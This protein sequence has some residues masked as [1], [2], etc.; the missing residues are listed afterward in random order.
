MYVCM[1]WLDGDVQGKYGIFVARRHGALYV[2]LRERVGVFC[3]YVC[4]YMRMYVWNLHLFTLTR[5]CAHMCPITMYRCVWLYA[6]MCYIYI[7]IYSHT[8]MG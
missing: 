5:I 4:M 2:Y 1:L 7:Y 8:Y 6:H 3:M